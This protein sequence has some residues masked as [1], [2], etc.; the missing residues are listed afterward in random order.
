MTKILKA[1]QTPINLSWRRVVLAASITLL[2]TA[3]GRP[4]EESFAANFATRSSPREAL[5]SLLSGSVAQ[6]QA[7]PADWSAVEREIIA[8]HSRVRQNPQSY[9]PILEAHLASMNANG[10]IPGG[11][12]ANC[13]LVTQEGQAAV[14][15]AISFLRSQPPVG[16]LKPSDAIATVAK[17]HAQ[18]QR[19]G[20]IG[21]VDTAGNRSPQRLTNAGVEYSRAGENID[22]G[23]M[24]AQDVL[25]SLIVDD[26]VA[27]RGH[28]TNIFDPLWTTAGAGCVAHATI[29]S[30]CVVNYTTMSRQ[31]KV[32]NDGT[33]DLLSLKVAGLDVL[34]GPLGVGASR[35]ITVAEGQRCSTDLTVEMGGGYAP[36][37]WRDV[38]LCGGMMTVDRQNRLNLSY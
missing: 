37:I 7:A 2:A 10:E 3:L 23:S 19:D 11:C 36:L 31:L 14:V 1:L 28:R 29:R 26:G 25:V 35:E 21:H 17:S 27:D 30:V 16:P 22:Y 15:E 18:S 12:G 13:T 5:P 20:A 8:E 33:V 24:T 6:A 9:I 32:V 38:L 4:A 34:G